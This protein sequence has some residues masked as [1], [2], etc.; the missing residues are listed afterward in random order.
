M[1]STC[2]YCSGKLGANDMLERFPVGRR[3]AF[4]AAKGRL[5]VVCTACRRWNLSPM[6]IRFEAIEDCERLYRSTYTRVSTGNIGLAKLK[7]GLELVRIGAPLRPEFAA[8]RY[9]DQFSGRRTR[10]YVKAGAMVLGAAG[11][12]IGAGAFL[13]PAAVMVSGAY[14]VIAMP[15][16]AMSMLGTTV[17]GGAMAADYMR[18]ERILAR[19]RLG[20]RTIQVRAKHAR[21][22]ELTLADE[23]GP[24]IGIQHDR[25]WTEFSGQQAMHA[26]TVLLASTNRRGASARLVQNAVAQIESFGDSA[27]YLGAASDRNGW[28]GLRPVSVMN[29]YRRLG[30]LNLNDTE[31]LAL[32][33]AVHED[34]ERRAIEGELAELRTA[35]A[36]AE[37]IAAIVDGMLTPLG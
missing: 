23:R 37:E 14:A 32:E 2:L 11:A 20:G 24:G 25:G 26:T 1:Y 22:V 28:R 33:M 34:V 7:D 12:S 8:W 21:S 9:S 36:E 10:A 16:L 29:A 6:E 3:I 4:D 13:A 31:R 19:F 18:H 5:W 17:F 27:H 30:P 15:V 35:W